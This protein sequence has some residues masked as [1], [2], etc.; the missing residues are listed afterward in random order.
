MDHENTRSASL[1]TRPT[2]YE[3]IPD[4]HR[5]MKLLWRNSIIVRILSRYENKI[6]K[7]KQKSKTTSEDQIVN[8]ILKKHVSFCLPVA[9]T[10]Y[11]DPM[12]CCYMCT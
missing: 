10:F 12:E 1:T 9:Y 3:L 7:S 5:Q 4:T 6:Q 8:R 11:V 2:N